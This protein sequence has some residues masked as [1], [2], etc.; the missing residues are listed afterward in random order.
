MQPTAD[1]TGISVIVKQDGATALV[2]YLNT[3]DRMNPWLITSE[4]M[5]EPH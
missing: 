5:H 4:A 1:P 2:T 3:L